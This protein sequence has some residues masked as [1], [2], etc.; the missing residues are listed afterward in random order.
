MI[1]GT[2]Y[3]NTNTYGDLK[4]YANMRNSIQLVIILVISAL[5]QRANFICKMGRKGVLSQT[6]KSKIVQGL[7]KNISTLQLAKELDRSHRTFKKHVTYPEICNGRS[8][9]G[10]ICKKA[11]V[12]H[13]AMSKIKREVRRN[14]LKT[15]KKA[16]KMLSFLM[17]Q[18]QPDAVS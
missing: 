1:L 3:G 8:D 13:R 12:S 15:R 9:K 7:H 6:E 17:C 5:Y 2:L 14:P 4:F 16:L 11:P 10:K 18:N